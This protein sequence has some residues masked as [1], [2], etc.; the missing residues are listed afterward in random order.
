M[1]I[2]TIE[3]LSSGTVYYATQGDSNLSVW[4]TFSSLTLKCKPLSTEC[5]LVM[6]FIMLYKVILT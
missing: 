6:L 3:W 5:F 4:L 1:Q 2:E